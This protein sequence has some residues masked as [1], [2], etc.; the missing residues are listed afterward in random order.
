MG[1]RL[2]TTV[3]SVLVVSC[4]MVMMDRPVEAAG[5]LCGKSLTQALSMICQS[6]PTL[7][8][9]N[10]RSKGDLVD[11][12]LAMDFDRRWSSIMGDQQSNELDG[13]V[14]MEQFKRKPFWLSRLFRPKTI[15]SGGTD[16]VME[17]EDDFIPQRFLMVKRG[18][19][20][21]CCYNSCTDAQLKSFC[22]S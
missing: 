6:Y 8:A 17:T 13:V 21:E 2:I 16:M 14:S 19:V 12:G 22:A 10:K 3:G 15:E 7:P 5:R 1:S 20:D 11:M 4:L 18:I 9:Y